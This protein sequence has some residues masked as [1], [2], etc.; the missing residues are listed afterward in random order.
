MIDYTKHQQDYI[1]VVGG[2]A[3][4]SAVEIIG[5]LE[6]EIERYR[7]TLEG[8]RDADYRTWKTDFDD[9]RDAFIVWVKSRARHVLNGG[10]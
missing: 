10:E 6:K 9:T 8:F 1:D 3:H 5:K 7:R 4:N 2:I